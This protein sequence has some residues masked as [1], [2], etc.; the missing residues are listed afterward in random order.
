MYANSSV[1]HYGFGTGSCNCNILISW[2]ATF[3]NKIFEIVQFGFGLLVHNFLIT[4]SCLTNRIP[5]YHPY[6]TVNHSLIVIVDKSIDNGLA[7]GFVHCEFGSLPV[8]R[9]PK[10]F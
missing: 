3:G 1:G 2:F 4:D 6:T 10:L 9:S 7:H 5:V 8:T